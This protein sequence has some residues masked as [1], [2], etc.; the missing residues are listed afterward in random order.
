MRVYYDKDC[1]LSL[2][3]AKQVAIVAMARRA[4]PTPTISR[5]PAST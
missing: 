3:Q 2:I 1:D 4:T 5:S